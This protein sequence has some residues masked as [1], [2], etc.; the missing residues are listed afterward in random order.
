MQKD[1]NDIIAESR[2][3]L[4]H[5]KRIVVD[6]KDFSHTGSEE[7]W[8]SSDIQQILESSLTLVMNEIKYKCEVRKEFATLPKVFCL[9]TR[10]NQV[11]MNLLLNAAQ[12][13][14]ERGVIT[15]R[16][17]QEDDQ[18]WIEIAD[19]GEGIEQK[20]MNRI[21]DPFF[22]TKPL[23]QGTGLGLSISYSIVEKH[24]GRIEVHS[25]V[26]KGSAFRVWLPLKQPNSHVVGISA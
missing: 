6:L 12:A 16:T 25:E 14:K 19:T 26:N 2:E 5:V 21:F 17:G 24:F 9:P 22:T 18:V 7:T 20:N 11:F 1:T 8:K 3:G 23:G 15:V 4:E 10:L 13:I